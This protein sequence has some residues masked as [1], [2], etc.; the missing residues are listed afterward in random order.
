MTDVTDTIV[1]MVT[2]AYAI[3]IN[4]LGDDVVK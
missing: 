3:A 4:R 2:L 1:M